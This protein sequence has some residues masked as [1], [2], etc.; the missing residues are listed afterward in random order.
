ML[1]P[2]SYAVFACFCTIF[3]DNM[4]PPWGVGWRKCDT[5]GSADVS[6]GIRK[7]IKKNI[8]FWM[9]FWLHVG[10]IWHPSWLH[11]GIIFR[12][13]FWAYS[14]CVFFEICGISDPANPQFW[15]SRLRAVRFFEFSSNRKQIQN[16]RKISP[17]WLPK[18]T[19]KPP[20]IKTQI[21]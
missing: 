1:D 4:A 5:C 2:A 7:T 16:E 6:R 15:C 9:P 3:F 13:S 21:N 18:S 12:Y 11:V 8:D 20:K 17:K 19:K 10:S 14:G